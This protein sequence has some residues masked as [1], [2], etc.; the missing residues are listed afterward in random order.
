MSS[1]EKRDRL[2]FEPRR[3]RKKEPPKAPATAQS[4]PPEP[5]N[6]SRRNPNDSSLAAIPD[7]VSKRM[8]RRMALFSGIPTALGISSFFIFYWIVRQEWFNL[9]TVVV[10][11]VSLGLFGVGVIGLSYGLFSTSW[12]EERP[13]SWLGFDEFQRNLGRAIAAWRSAKQEARGD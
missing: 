6:S 3:K 8:V 7:R 5:Q 1:E 4:V 13:G 9:P 10:L 12:D 11:F 2:P